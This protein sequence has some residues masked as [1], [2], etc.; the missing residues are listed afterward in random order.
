MREAST[1][2]SAATVLPAPVAC[3]NQKRLAALGSSGCSA[4]LASSSAPAVVVPVLRLLVGLVLLEVRSSSSPGSPRRR[5]SDLRRRLDVAARAVRPLPFGRGCASASSAV[6]VPDSASTWCGV[7]QRAVDERAAPPRSAA[8]RGRAAATTRGARRP[9]GP[10][11]PASSSASAASSAA[12][13]ALPGASA[14]AGVL[15]L[16]HEGLSGEGSGPLEVVGDRGM[17]VGPMRPLA[18]FSHAWLGSAMREPRTRASDPRRS[19]VTPGTAGELS[20]GDLP[21]D[22]RGY[23]H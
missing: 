17:G 12:R 20:T 7:E 11:A 1:K 19:G 23:P 18:G 9:T 6:S 5:A 16:E 15:A 10:S 22:T 14:S 2:P 21:C 8:A 13:R 4:Q 3:S